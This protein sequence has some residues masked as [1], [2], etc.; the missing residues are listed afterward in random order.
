[1]KNKMETLASETKFAVQGSNGVTKITGYAAVFG[2][3]DSH[4]DII[5]KGA[6]SKTIEAFL[7]RKVNLY[8]SHSLDARDLVGSISLLQ[9]DDYGLYFESE[10][11][12]AGSAQDIAIKAKEGHL[13]EVSIGFFITDKELKKDATGR[14]IRYIKEIDLIEISLVSRASNPMART[15][16]VKEEHMSEENNKQEV[17]QEVTEVQSV[18]VKQETTNNNVE[19]KASMDQKNNELIEMMMKKMEAMEA[20]LNAPVKK[21]PAGV[22]EKKEIEFE[23]KNEDELDA[24]VGLVNGEISGR[25]YKSLSSSVAS[26]GGLLVPEKFSEKILEEKERIRRVDGMIEKVQVSGPLSIIDFD[27]EEV[28]GAHDE[29]SSVTVQDI[30]NAFGKSTLDPQDFSVI[31]KVPRRLERRSF[32]ALE[33]FLA[34]RYA[35]KHMDQKEDFILTGTGVKQPIGIV[36]LLDD[37]AVNTVTAATVAALDYDDLVDC[38]LKL[39]E[40]YR[41]NGVFIVNKAVLGQVMKLKDSNNLPIWNRP[42]SADNPSTLLGRPIFESKSL[43]DGSTAGDTPLVFADLSLYMMA[44]EKGFTVEVLRE[45]YAGEDKIGLKIGASY[46]GMPIDKNGFARI[47]ITN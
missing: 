19:I 29:G 11:S 47:D 7:K 24:F 36:T 33:G 45:L 1:M 43:P 22:V 6:F 21:T 8:S 31:V 4:G 39:D 41:S 28:L 2:N 35:K 25:E 38:M 10:V 9:E 18:E 5:E 34:K 3:V 42:V 14:R 26:N 12:S 37:L 20:A 30:A 17:K 44:E 46:D 13:N 27:F 32:I 16:L 15:L 40:E 23:I